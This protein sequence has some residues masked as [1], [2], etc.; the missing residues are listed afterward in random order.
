MPSGASR[1]QTIAPPADDVVRAFDR[2]AERARDRVLVLSPA[3]QTTAGHL[4][5]WSRQAAARMADAALAPGSIIGLVAPNGPAF[6]AG[7]LGVR[8]AGCT[9]LLLDVTAATA[10]RARVLDAIGAHALLFCQVD[11][12]ATAF[13]ATLERVSTARVVD[14]RP[15][16]A[17]IQM[18]SGSTGTP[19][20]VALSARA[21]LADEDALARTMGIRESDRILAALPM[22]HRYGFT[23]LSLAAIARGCQ[24]VMPADAGPLAPIHAGD[25]C[26]ATV[27]PTVPAYLQ[28]VL[29]MSQP[30]PW[31]ASVRLC[32][33]AGAPLPPATAAQFREFSG[34]PVHVFYGASECGGICYDRSGDAG[35]RGT[36][37]TPVEGVSISI[38]PAD[39]QDAEG[40][41]AVTSEGVGD[42]YVPTPDAR[43][44]GGQFLTADLAAWRGGEIELLRRAD[45]IINVRGFKVDPVEVERVIA[46]LPGVD[47][48]AVTGTDGSEGSG[49]LI[50]AV[51]AS[52]S[53]AVDAAAVTAWC[54]PRLADYKVPRSVAIVEALPR[55]AR[56]KLDRAALDHA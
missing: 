4:D 14:P 11:A 22:S 45:R 10:D 33:T 25:A 38:Q 9:A 8:R 31:P 23:T 43:L 3:W 16:W 36:V 5:D 40:L 52:R 41:L 46:A 44:G 19:R 32:L 6:L 21:L 37:G 35:E 56:G 53:G 20:G 29:R 13:S 1:N 47:E 7:L 55:T 54:R 2:V 30:P 28:A 26:G 27:F 48:V 24:L 50:R 42:T 15:D 49:T 12:R 17:V 51:V 39:A 18:T 34:R